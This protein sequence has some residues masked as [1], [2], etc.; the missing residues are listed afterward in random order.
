[1]QGDKPEKSADPQSDLYA[2]GVTLYQL[3][4]GKLPYG[5]VLPY[6]TTRYAKDPL[7]PSR[8][9]PE[10]PAWLDHIV[11]KAV[12]RNEHQRF[13]SADEFLLALENGEAGPLDALSAPATLHS[14]PLSYWKMALGLSVLLNLLLVFW[15]VVWPK[16][17]AY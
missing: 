13:A 11:L 7:P 2:L 6:Q 16:I 5:E 3:L 9:N 4:T 17:S 1:V 8:H 15:F 14:A 10:I 12:A